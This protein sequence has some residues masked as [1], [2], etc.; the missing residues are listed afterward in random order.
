M[1]NIET[2]LQ[3]HILIYCQSK[4]ISIDLR[5][6][7]FGDANRFYTHDAEF[8]VDCVAYDTDDFED[9]KKFFVHYVDIMWKRRYQMNRIALYIEDIVDMDGWYEVVVGGGL[10]TDEALASGGKHED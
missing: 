7:C 3:E 8:C 10:F 4:N 2:K 6:K 5:F 9:I 1:E